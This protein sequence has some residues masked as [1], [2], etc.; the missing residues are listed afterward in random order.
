MSRE[1]ADKNVC[2]TGQFKVPR[3]FTIRDAFCEK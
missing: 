2:V 3:D 1:L